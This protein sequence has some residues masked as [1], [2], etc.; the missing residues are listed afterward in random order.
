M[1]P[2]RTVNFRLQAFMD[3]AGLNGDG[4]ARSIRAVGDQ[5]GLSL[6]CGRATVGQWLRGRN[7]RPPIPTLA[8]EALSRA[9]DR[10]V[11]PAHLGFEADSS[12]DLAFWHE[13]SVAGQLQVLHQ[14][15]N[16]SG[17]CQNPRVYRVAALRP[18]IWDEPPPDLARP[19]TTRPLGTGRLGRAEVEDAETMLRLF[20]QADS[21]AGAG[22]VRPALARYLADQIRV[23][24]TAPARDD[25]RREL[26][27]I[28]ARLAYLCG[29][30]FFDDELHGTAQRYYHVAAE[31]AREAG[32]P[33][34]HAMALRALSVQARLL[35][36]PRPALALAE[37]SLSDAPT[38][39]DPLTRAFLTGQLAVAHAADGDRYR[40]LR[41]LSAT[42]HWFAKGCDRVDAPMAYNHASLAHQKAAVLALLHQRPQA[43]AALE[44]SVRQRPAHERRSRAITKARLAEL[45]LSHGHLEQATATWHTFLDDYRCILS[46]RARSALAIMRASLRPYKNNR[47]AGEVLR[48]ALA[49]P[50]VGLGGG[51]SMVRV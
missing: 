20:G 23:W 34:P 48:R 46:G 45:Q 51:Q 5:V 26:L 42:E 39:C 7:P 11:S 43:I 49:L 13:R 15:D 16:V 30:L 41:Q 37:A 33:G 14:L 22:H 36:H 31:L 38:D 10:D 9:L 40:A 50:Y 24:T 47:L 21:R 3:E 27:A 32:R 25:I 8:A 12:E 29:F 19:S 44:L 1:N 18:P 17:P 6:R 2:L 35:G 4:L 28:A